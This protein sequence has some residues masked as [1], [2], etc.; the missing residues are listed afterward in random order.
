MVHE[1]PQPAV[2]SL[3]PEEEIRA[4]LLRLLDL[5]AE[6]VAQKILRERDAKDNQAN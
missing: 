1:D 4:A 5:L 6:Q 2:A 3:P